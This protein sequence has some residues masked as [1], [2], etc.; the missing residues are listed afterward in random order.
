MALFANQRDISLLRTINR[1]LMGDIISTQAA[2]YKFKLEETETNIYGEAPDEKYYIG[3]ILLN[4]LVERKDQSHPETDLGTDFSWG[5]RFKFLRDDLLVKTKDFNTATMFGANLLPEVGDIIYYQEDYHEVH[6]VIENQ[7][8]M[9]KNLDFP[10]E[11]N[12]LNPGLGTF[13][14]NVSIITEC[15]IVSGDKLGITQ[16]RLL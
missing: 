14:W 1:E 7:Y 16:E 11:S 8:F 5:K 6:N 15:H 13:G 9:G 10:N 2:F 3:P 12:P 4:C